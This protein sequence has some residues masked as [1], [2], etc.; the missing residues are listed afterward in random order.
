MD[1]IC[2]I[3][4]IYIYTRIE[5]ER[6]RER[7][8]RCVCVCVSLSL[9]VSLFLSAHPW[10]LFWEGAGIYVWLADLG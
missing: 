9:S 8:G 10:A 3:Y 7:D 5:R 4:D 1:T 6:D 2:N